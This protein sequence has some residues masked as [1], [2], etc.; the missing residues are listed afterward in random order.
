[1]Q[2]FEARFEE[3]YNIS[4]HTYFTHLKSRHFITAGLFCFKQ[5][6]LTVLAVHFLLDEVE[7]PPNLQNQQER[8]SRK[9]FFKSGRKEI[10]AILKLD[11]LKSHGSCEI[12]HFSSRLYGI[13][14]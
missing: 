13:S 9:W 3:I 5:F 4:Q 2:A 7:L 11:S 12:I 1:M 10:R 8:Q 14:S 6:C